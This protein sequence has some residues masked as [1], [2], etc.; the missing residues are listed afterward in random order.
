MQS[1]GCE[2]YK[3][4]VRHRIEAFNPFTLENAKSKID[5]FFTITNWVKLAI[6]YC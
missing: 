5:K 2:G 1:S 6:K 3:G 4:T